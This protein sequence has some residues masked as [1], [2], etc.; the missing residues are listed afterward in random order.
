MKKFSFIKKKNQNLV[1]FQ[2][3]LFHSTPTS[4]IL[5]A[6]YE[7]EEFHKFSHHFLNI[8]N[9]QFSLEKVPMKHCL[10]NMWIIKPANLNQG[11]FFQFLIKIAKK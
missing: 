11:I 5:T 10:K 1:K 3:S 9:Q 8:Q 4:F 7:N 2:Y 6:G